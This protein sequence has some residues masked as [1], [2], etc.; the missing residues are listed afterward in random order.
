MRVLSIDLETCSEADLKK[1]GTSRYSKDPSTFVTVFAWAFD[2][3]PVCSITSP[4]GISAH[5][6]LPGEVY[7]HLH[8]GGLIAAWN[9]WFEYCLISNTL[10]IPL[11]PEQ[12]TCSMQRALYAGLPAALGDAGTALGLPASL[13]KDKTAHGL[14]LKCAKPKSI[15]PFGERT[16]TTDDSFALT[17]LAGYCKQDVVAERAVACRLPQLPPMEQRISI[18]DR[19][20]NARGIRID[21]DLI[22]KMMDIA[23][24]EVIRLNVMAGALTNG[25]V[26]SPG[27]QSKRVLDWMEAQ[28]VTLANTK[29]QTVAETI[30]TAEDAG[31]PGSVVQLLQIRR[32][33]AKSSLA[34]L[35][36]MLGAVESDEKIRGTIAY[37]G[38]SRTGRF[39]G[40]I[41]QPQNFPRPSGEP[42]LAIE[43]ILQGMDA[44]GLR[45]IHGPPLGVLS[46]CLRGTMIP[47]SGKVFISFDLSQIEARVI[48]WLCDQLDLLA[49]FERGDDVYQYTADKL[50]LPTRQAGKATVLGLGFGQGH[51]HF[52]EFAHNYNVEISLDESKVIVNDWRAANP[53]IVQGWYGLQTAAHELVEQWHL[54]RAGTHSRKVLGDRIEV[55]VGTTREGDPTLALTLPA[56]RRLYYRNPRLEML[57]VK[58]A[59]VDPNGDPVLD[60]KG[61]PMEEIIYKKGLVFDGVDQKTNKWGPVRTWGSKLMENCVQAIARDVI[62]EAAVRIDD[63][64]IAD[65]VFS[66]H[67]E[68]VFEVDEPQKFE[69]YLAIRQEV[70]RVPDWAEGLPIAAEGSI[71]LERYGKG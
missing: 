66:V 69:A 62:I 11:K 15:D 10:G 60:D 3:D 5:H 17:A 45:I 44:D 49:V 20:S 56:G 14:M 13:Q 64:K 70:L 67:D 25:A 28:G 26:S 30:D 32:E 65:L 1:V 34:K 42:E 47:S 40:R 41:I 71:L 63:L 51:K 33:V 22:P 58:R 46:S 36:T 23:K 50:G 12:M 35:K 6:E 21:L 27:T 19:K 39:A 61:E 55:V 38:A 68:L 24:V 52:V 57:P 7:H 29:K 4:R 18:L 31:L 37:Y 53:N 16:Y 59:L 2:Q 43:G 8:N 54:T 9:A 48:A